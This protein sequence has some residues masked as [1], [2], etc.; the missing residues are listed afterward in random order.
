VPAWQFTLE[1]QRQA[2][3][4]GRRFK[5]TAARVAFQKVATERATW[6]FL[7]R[8][9]MECCVSP[10]MA[11]LVRPG[12]DDDQCACLYRALAWMCRMGAV[13]AAFVACGVV[14]RLVADLSATN[15]S[16][17]Q[18]CQALSRL[19]HI[20]EGKAVIVAAGGVAALVI[21]L[22]TLSC[23]KRWRELSTAC[24]ACDTLSVLVEDSSCAAD[25]RA[26]LSACGGV[27]TLVSVLDAHAASA[28]MASA[29]VCALR[30]LAV[31]DA[32]LGAIAAAGG[33]AALKAV[34]ALHAACSASSCAA[35][36]D[37]GTPEGCPA[38]VSTATHV[39]LRLGTLDS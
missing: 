7:C 34:L 21:V 29:A 31:D 12:I 18:L 22:A 30:N 28:A 6:S 8:L 32:C 25:A 14:P 13:A 4:A 11:A 10:L 17:W 37:T 38:L 39:L 2:A 19:A 24:A 1:E 36:G 9:L 20:T 3:I 16:T 33:S 26:A 15:R 27:R 23:S 5:P 35:D